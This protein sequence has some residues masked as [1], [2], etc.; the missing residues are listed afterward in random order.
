[1]QCK[2]LMEIPATEDERECDYLFDDSISRNID[3]LSCQLNATV[4]I[5][6]AIII[7]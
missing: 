3:L 2:Y 7:I 6:H 5:P 1:M 4:H